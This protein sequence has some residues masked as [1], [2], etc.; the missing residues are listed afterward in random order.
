MELLQT[1][2][3]DLIRSDDLRPALRRTLSDLRDGLGLRA[4]ALRVTVR[5][6]ELDERSGDDRETTARL[7][8]ALPPQASPRYARCAATARSRCPSATAA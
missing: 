5:D 7:E 8:R 6:E 2:A 4:A 3:V 1:L